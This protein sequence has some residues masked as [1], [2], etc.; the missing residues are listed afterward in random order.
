[1]AKQRIPFERW[2]SSEA[3]SRGCQNSHFLLAGTL[4]IVV[5]FTGTSAGEV[6]CVVARGRGLQR[7]HIGEQGVDAW[8]HIE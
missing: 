6:G 1:M 7:E 5:F 3:P 2:Q 8:E 4:G